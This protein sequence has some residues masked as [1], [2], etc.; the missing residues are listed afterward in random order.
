MYKKNILFRTAHQ[1]CHSKFLEHLVLSNGPS[2]V[3]FI[4]DLRS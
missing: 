1:A 4:V 2:K 3:M